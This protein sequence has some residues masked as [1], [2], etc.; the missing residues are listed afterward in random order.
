[1]SNFGLFRGI[2]NAIYPLDGNSNDVSGNANNGTD[3][4]MSY[5]LGRFGDAGV[6]N[7]STSRIALPNNAGLKPTVLTIIAWYKGTQA[8]QGTIFQNWNN[9]SSKY[10]GF[11]IGLDGHLVRMLVAKGTGITPVTDFNFQ[12]S[13]SAVDDGKWHMIVGTWDGSYI[14]IYI[15]GNFETSTA[16]SATVTY[17]ATQYPMIGVRQDTSATYAEYISGSVDN[18]VLLP[19]VLSDQ[20]IRRYYAWSKGML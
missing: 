5:G 4:N 17:T 18:I 9:T 7:G 11:F 8:T 16:W 14:K 12:Y 6:F 10:Y 1:M 19:Y 3:S 2:S 15:D 20:D 13:G